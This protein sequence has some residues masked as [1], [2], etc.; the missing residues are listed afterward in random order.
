MPVLVLG[1]MGLG[2][3]LVYGLVRSFCGD[4]EVGGECDEERGNYRECGERGAIATP[5]LPLPSCVV[6]TP[7]WTAPSR[8]RGC[9][10]R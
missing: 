9:L 4:G 2:L 10:T 7:Q 8:A 1:R 6:L 3:L 5:T